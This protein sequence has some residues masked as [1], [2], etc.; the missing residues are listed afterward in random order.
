MTANGNIIAVPCPY[1]LSNQPA[2]GIDSNHPVKPKH[3]YPTV[4]VMT[5]L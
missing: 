2:L 1:T 3:M 4:E 5:D